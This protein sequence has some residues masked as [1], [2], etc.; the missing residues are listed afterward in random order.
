MADTPAGERIARLEVQMGGLTEELAEA[1]VAI[2]E[3]TAA[4]HELKGAFRGAFW[5]GSIITSAVVGVG[6]VL[7][8]LYDKLGGH[9]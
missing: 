8:W 9:T 4:L 6:T 7:M 2:K 1:K 3:L 5:L